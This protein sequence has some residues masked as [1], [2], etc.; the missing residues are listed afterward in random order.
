[1]KDS[2]ERW[3]KAAKQELKGEDPIKSLTQVWG[4]LEVFPY[5]DQSDLNVKV[6][7]LPDRQ[8]TQSSAPN[9][10]FNLP[11]VG[12]GSLAQQ[13]EVILDHLQN[14]ADGVFLNVSANTDLKKLLS[15]VKPEFCF[16]GFEYDSVSTDLLEAISDLESAGKLTGALFCPKEVRL[17]PVANVFKGY[18]NFRCFGIT[19]T[20]DTPEEQLLSC[21]QKAIETLD[22]LT[23][24]AFSAQSIFRQ[25]AFTLHTGNN[26]FLD[27]AR[28]R[29]LRILLNR[30]AL[31]YG[32]ENESTFIRIRIAP[33]VKETYQPHGDL[34]VNSFAAIAAVT[35]SADA[36]TIVSE[37]PMSR[38][39][40]RTSR[41][42]SMLLA[43]ES[44]LDKVIDP[45]AGSYF[46]ESLT[47]T[48]VEK[49]WNQI[50]TK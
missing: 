9:H 21:L 15:E 1:M 36:V 12:L 28:I 33:L 45:F 43:E 37:N 11:E 39:L 10:W 35:A 25:L 32:L 49:I 6:F 30:L 48:L 8:S 19:E 18:S 3:K 22:T 20:G 13:N 17:L 24:Y 34:V 29:S 16:L 47:N 40:N 38:H 5:Y 4:N 44:K 27:V 2:K 41:N 23:D 42:I 7:E 14:G 31:A 46:I 50:A 26:F